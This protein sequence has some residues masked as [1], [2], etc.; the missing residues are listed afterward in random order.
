MIKKQPKQNYRQAPQ[1]NKKQPAKENSQVVVEQKLKILENLFKKGLI[2]E[3]EY[4]KK[5]VLC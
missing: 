1:V 2:S 4:Q 5:E 3:S